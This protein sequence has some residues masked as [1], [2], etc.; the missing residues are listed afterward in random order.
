MLTLA[1]SVL[2]AFSS[3]FPGANATWSQLSGGDPLIECTTV[4]TEPW[5]RATGLVDAPLEQVTAT[6]KD[7]AAHQ[8]LFDSIVRIDVVEPDTMHIVLDFPAPLS[9]RDYVAKYTVLTDGPT[10]VFHWESVLHEAA[11]PTSGVVRLPDMAGEWRLTAEAGKTRV[12][13][14]WEADVQGSL[15][16]FTQNKARTIAGHKAL[17]DIRKATAAAH[18]G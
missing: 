9:D 5:C 1:L 7:M 6:L 18:G 14:L 12:V 4:G 2:P 15:P 13:Y 10:Q 8:A 11:P 3:T 17:E 16:A